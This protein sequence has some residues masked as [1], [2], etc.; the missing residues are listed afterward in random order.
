MDELLSEFLTETNESLS[1]LDVEV[2]NLERNPDNPDL[3][4]N[5][6]RLVHTIKG[7]CGFLGLRRLEAV[8]HASENVLGKI[9]D[10]ALVVSAEG[11]SL[12]LA[13]LDRIKD[14]LGALEATE[15]EPDGNDGE[16]IRQLDA[17]AEGAAAPASDVVPEP[18][19]EPEP[20]EA[21]VEPDPGLSRALKPGE[22]S[23]EELERVFQETASEVA[24]PAPKLAAQGR[25][26]ADGE[27]RI[28]HRQPVNPR[29]CR[30][31][32]KPYDHGERAG[33]DPQP[34]V[35]DGPHPGRQRVQ[36]FAAAAQPR[37]HRACRKAS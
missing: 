28:L 37:D 35:A 36:G 13:S 30:S 31:A 20:V 4:D 32:G 8:A 34:V 26:G 33:A 29:Q 21:P 10:G 17:M 19:S 14:I 1:T 12:I 24:A 25:P 9:R 7:T 22:V 23:L 6:F 11:V 3:I 18:E 27:R 15:S 2:V 5:I 16:L